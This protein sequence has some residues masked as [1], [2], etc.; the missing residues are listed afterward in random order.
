MIALFLTPMVLFGG[1]LQFFSA[2][3]F[4][5]VGLMILGL[6]GLAALSLFDR[7]HI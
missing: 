2:I 3:I 4:P 1:S 6:V 7:Q 5:G